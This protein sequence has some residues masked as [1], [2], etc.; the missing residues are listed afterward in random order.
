MRRLLSAGFVAIV[1]LALLVGL[2]LLIGSYTF[3]PPLAERAVA[4]HV[5]ERFQGA[6]A[7]EVDLES[8]PPP[9][10]L[11]G[12]FSG[13]H[14]RLEGVEVNGVRM[15]SV[16]ADL[17]PFG[18]RV[19]DSIRTGT[20]IGNGPLSG[21]LRVELS[22][23]E[24]ADLAGDN[25][26]LPVNGVEFEEED[27]MVVRS[28]A[29][30]LDVEIPVEVVGKF[31]VRD[32]SLYYQTTGVRAADV[33][34]PDPIADSLLDGVG[35]AYSLEGLPYDIRVKDLDVDGDRLVL[36][37]EMERILLGDSG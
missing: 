22:E 16:A 10:V 14:I 34:L 11:A 20:A 13:G 23:H 9:S 6:R 35:F 18:V 4:R 12:E 7:P 26:A 29:R 27:T 33:P 37:G 17:D 36:T 30:V 1:V 15:E 2:V 8:D 19:A 28:R 24:L 5:G 25:T 21:K 32:M 31:S 3:L